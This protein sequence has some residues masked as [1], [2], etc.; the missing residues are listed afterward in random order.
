VPTLVVHVPVAVRVQQPEIRE[1][2]SPAVCPPSKLVAVPATRLSERLAADETSAI[3]GYP[4]S[5]EPLIAVQVLSQQAPGALCNGGSPRGVVRVRCP[6]DREVAC[7][8]RL[9]CPIQ[10]DGRDLTRLVPS[11]AGEHPWVS[12]G[13][14]EVWLSH[15][16]R[17]LLG[18]SASCPTP[19]PLRDVP[20]HVPT[21]VCTGPMPVIVGPPADQ[22]VAWLD[23]LTGPG[24]WLGCDRG[25]HLAPEGFDT[26]R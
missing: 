25:S 4:Q 11:L 17:T 5:Q 1:G 13:R 21:G 15:P 18:V 16:S 22:R 7:H 8:L 10:A 2:R 23:H 24:R 26:L 14:W 6:F 12:A 3:L 20:V 19:Q 9:L